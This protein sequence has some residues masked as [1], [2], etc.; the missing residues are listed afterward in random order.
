MEWEQ[1]V[2]GRVWHLFVSDYLSVS[3]LQV[4]PG[5]C[6]SRHYHAERNNL[7]A[8]VSGK[9]IIQEWHGDS[10]FKTVL[11]P[12][13]IYMVE[14]GTV[15]R[16]CVLEEG[17]VVEIYQSNTPEG[18]VSLEDIHRLDVGGSWSDAL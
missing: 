16:F 14:A 17:E 15:H 8:V 9:L 11:K 2:W 5:F 13:S 4:N 18:K 7:F 1:K 3:F 10:L 12:G 6:C